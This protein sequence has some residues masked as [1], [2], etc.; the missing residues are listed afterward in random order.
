MEPAKVIKEYK[1]ENI[2]LQAEINRYAKTV[3]RIT[4]EKEWL[5]GKLEGLDLLSKKKMIDSN[6]SHNQSS[7]QS[8][9]KNI[10]I[11]SQC[12]L[13]K[14]SRSSLYYK[15][16]IN[17]KKLSI[18]SKI[19]D[20]FKEIPIYGEL[21]VHRQL[22]EDG[23]KVSLNTVSKYRKEMNLKAILAV[24]PINTTIPNK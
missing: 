7:N 1:D 12:K 24:K 6:P 14:I 8:S 2:K 22:L 13:L 16:S 19:N 3:G 15:P 21:K 17:E 9:N 20:V 10:S 5:E 11:S 23:Y 18:K 4:M